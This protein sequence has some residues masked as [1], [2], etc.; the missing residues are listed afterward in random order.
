MKHNFTTECNRLTEIVLRNFKGIG[1]RPVSIPLRRL[2][3]LFGENSAGKSTILHSLYYIDSILSGYNY[4]TEYYHREKT[5]P[6]NLDIGNFQ[7]L[8]NQHDTTKKIFMQFKFDTHVYNEDDMQN[9]IDSSYD[10]ELSVSLEIS[11]DPKDKYVGIN[12]TTI[13]IDGKVISHSVSSDISY[14]DMTHE[15]FEPERENLVNFLKSNPEFFQ[16]EEGRVYYTRFGDS[17]SPFSDIKGFS[18]FTGKIKPYEKEIVAFF[19]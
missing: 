15:I 14:F 17:L 7:Q 4:G 10:S 1:D 18:R 8:V 3:L 11:Q 13:E 19:V 6:T 9:G 16:I 5:K 12:A 2:T